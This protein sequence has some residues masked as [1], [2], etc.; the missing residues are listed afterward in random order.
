MI[1]FAFY[2]AYVTS[3]FR[4]QPWS[5]V[6]SICPRAN[7]LVSSVRPKTRR[8]GGPSLSGSQRRVI[9][10]LTP[11]LTSQNHTR[12]FSPKLNFTNTFRESE[13]LRNDL[14]LWE[15]ALLSLRAVQSF[16]LLYFEGWT[17]R[18][19]LT[20][21]LQKSHYY[22]RAESLH[23]LYSILFPVQIG[24]FQELSGWRTRWGRGQRNNYGKKRLTTGESARNKAACFGKEVEIFSERCG[25]KKKERENVRLL[26]F[27]KRQKKSC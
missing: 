10:L 14:N 21:T 27:N 4:F 17:L 8:D 13:L 11:Q 3:Q 20:P 5:C 19:P 24:L 1:T 23:E 12:F 15:P 2:Q 7:F 22:Y 18:A 6:I 26:W 25:E 9:K 16:Y